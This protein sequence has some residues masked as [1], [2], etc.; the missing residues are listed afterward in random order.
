[1]KKLN[2]K[3]SSVAKMIE[4]GWTDEE[5]KA[6]INGPRSKA[7]EWDEGH[8]Y[9]RWPYID[10]IQIVG[11]SSLLTREEKDAYN[12]YH[13]KH[14][15]TGLGSSSTSNK[16]VL[17]KFDRLAEFCKDNTEALALIAELRPKPKFN[18]IEEM[19]GVE[20]VQQLKSKV[21]IA[22]VMYRGPNGEFFETDKPAEVKLKDFMAKYDDEFDCRWTKQQ[23]IE[24]VAK[25]K[26]NGIDISNVIIGL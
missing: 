11:L 21:S 15:P 6:L 25:L 22:Y 7:A 20:S 13:S 10:G 2:K 9:F 5:I 19:F 12:A 1:M 26:K 18:L 16:E 8:T 14:G 24:N 17:E 3:Y 23:V 4:D